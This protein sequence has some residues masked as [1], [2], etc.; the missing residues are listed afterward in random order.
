[1]ESIDEK[2]IINCTTNG[3]PDEDII[4]AKQ[5]YKDLEC[6]HCKKFWDCVGMPE[7]IDKC[8]LFEDRSEET[9]KE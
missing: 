1:M 6:F 3:I 4:R 5:T 8:L 9:E 7:G 2:D